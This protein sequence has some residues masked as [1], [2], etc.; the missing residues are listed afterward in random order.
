TPPM[1]RLR[2]PPLPRVSRQHSLDALREFAAEHDGRLD[3]GS[4]MAIR[5]GQHPEWPARN[6]VARHFGSWHAAL[7]AAGLAHRAAA[8]PERF[9]NR[10]RAWFDA[11]RVE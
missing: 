11:Q 1:G 8:A 5:R 10:S 6:T 9:A 3:I 2:R 7:E 4:Y